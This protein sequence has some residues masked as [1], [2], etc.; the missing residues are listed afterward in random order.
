MAASLTVL[1]SSIGKKFLMGL[2]GLVWSGFVLTHMAGNMLI[3]A[4]AEAF[5]RYGHAIVSNPALPLA[6]TLLVLTLL[7]HAYL[8]L[9][10]SFDNRRA[11]PSRYA[12]APTPN[13]QASAASRT[14]AATGS[15]ILAFIILHIAHFKYGTHYSATY[16]GVEMRDLHRLVIETFHKPGYVA[17][18]VVALFFLGFHLSHGFS[19]SFQ[20]LGLNHPRYTPWV[21]KAACAYAIIVAGGF[22]AQPLYVFLLAK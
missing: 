11:R 1:R 20:S 19:S 18:Y 13:K 6:E 14:M 4:G 15:L 17:W 2:T 16:A 7:A 22:I 10:L 9:S 5:N 21:K 8:A 3:F 12:V